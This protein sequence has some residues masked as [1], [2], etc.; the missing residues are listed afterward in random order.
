MTDHEVLAGIKGSLERQE[1][2][3]ERLVA[4]AGREEQ[5]TME[6]V[7]A[8]GVLAREV[9]RAC[10][11]ISRAITRACNEISRATMAG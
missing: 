2:H 10:N 3:L 8:L 6:V 1:Y 9:A 5:A 4:A 7:K 11:E